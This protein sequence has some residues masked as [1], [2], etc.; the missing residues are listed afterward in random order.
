MRE[1]II[2]RITNHWDYSLE[3]IF[4]IKLDDVYNLSDEQLLNLYNSIFE[5]GV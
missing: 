1:L 2:N 5:L 3:E 4:D